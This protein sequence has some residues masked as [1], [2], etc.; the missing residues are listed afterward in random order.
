M[1]LDENINDDKKLSTAPQLNK[2]DLITRSVTLPVETGQEAKVI[3]LIEKWGADAIRD[4]D[5]TQLSNDL[6]TLGLDVYSTICLVRADQE[7][8]KK[9]HDC[10]P[11]KFL[12]STPTSAQDSFLEVDLMQHYF[13]DKYKINSDDNPKKYWQVFNR[14]TG[15]ELPVEKWSFDKATGKVLITDA[16]AYHLYTVNFM[17]YQIWDSVSMYNHLSNG[18]AIDPIV[19]VD[20][21]SQK[22]Y[23]M[24]LN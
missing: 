23:T 6:L 24:I 13:S 15:Q 9:N 18:W 20:P 16:Q 12:M 11:M 4:C 1:L 17:V 2:S 22:A 14:T 19:S 3:E 21:F 5:G 7:W 10:L 8:T